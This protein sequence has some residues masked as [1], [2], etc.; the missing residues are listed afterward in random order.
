M[1]AIAGSWAY[2]LSTV[3]WYILARPRPGGCTPLW[4]R[5]WV[6]SSRV[7]WYSWHGQRFYLVLGNSCFLKSCAV[8][9]RWPVAKVLQ[10]AKERRSFASN[11]RYRVWL[12]LRYCLVN[13]TLRW[14]RVTPSPAKNGCI[15]FVESSIN[16]RGIS[17]FRW[18]STGWCV[19][20]SRRPQ[21]GQNTLST[22]SNIV[23][24]VQSWPWLNNTVRRSQIE[25][26]SLW[27][28][29]VGSAALIGLRSLFSKFGTV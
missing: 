24:G 7:G 14:L 9:T 2:K 17:P 8:Q 26:L 11:L 22:K 28:R 18:N 4:L 3:A 21:D 15:I 5:F 27:F 1:P 23:D 16:Q 6:E 13:P 25:A 10:D 29:S 20:G 12:K 19:I